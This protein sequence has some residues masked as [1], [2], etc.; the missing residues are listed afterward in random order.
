[1]LFCLY[2]VLVNYTSHVT[3]VPGSMSL[4]C[5]ISWFT[6]HFVM[7]PFSPLSIHCFVYRISPPISLFFILYKFCCDFFVFVLNCIY[8][9]ISF[10]ERKKKHNSR[11]NYTRI[12]SLVLFDCVSQCCGAIVNSLWLQQDTGLQVVSFRSSIDGQSHIEWT[13]SIVHNSMFH[14]Y[15][16]LSVMMMGAKS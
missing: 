7:L 12:R 3:I 10:Q 1:M 14:V 6:F 15:H 4:W 5:P 2:A 9:F 11:N 8:H 16:H 13:L